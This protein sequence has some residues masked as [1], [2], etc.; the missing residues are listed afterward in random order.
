MQASFNL[1][2]T[3]INKKKMGT[4]PPPLQSFRHKTV[5]SSQSEQGI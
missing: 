2:R 4:P 1:T 5:I 3:N